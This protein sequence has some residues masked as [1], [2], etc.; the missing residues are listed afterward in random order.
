MLSKSELFYM[1]K[2]IVY[3]IKYDK[4]LISCVC[5]VYTRVERTVT[6]V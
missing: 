5:I 3:M 1:S 4:I 6:Y 2:Y